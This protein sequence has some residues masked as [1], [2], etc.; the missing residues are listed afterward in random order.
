MQVTRTLLSSPLNNNRVTVAKAQPMNVSARSGIN[1]TASAEEFL[2][3]QATH[4]GES[5]AGQWSR[6]FKEFFQP[7]LEMGTGSGQGGTAGQGR[8]KTRK[9]GGSMASREDSVRKTND[10]FKDVTPP[11]A[12]PKADPEATT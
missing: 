12:E 6:R 7:F 4:S 11:K 2:G 1:A 5:L 10:M 3:T 8:A 9:A